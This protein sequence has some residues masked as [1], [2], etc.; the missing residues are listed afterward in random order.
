[1]STDATT[2]EEHNLSH[3]PLQ[4]V[5]SM[6]HMVEAGRKTNKLLRKN[7]C[8]VSYLSLETAKKAPEQCEDL[9]LKN[10]GHDKMSPF[11]R[12]V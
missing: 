10:S 6:L 3:G 7:L 8:V 1:M 12:T 11:T 5:H 4:A 9:R 2:G